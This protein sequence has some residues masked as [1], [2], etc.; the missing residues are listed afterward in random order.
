MKKIKCECCQKNEA[1]HVCEE[2]NTLYC[3]EC[4]SE[5]DYECDCNTPRII[6][7]N[8]ATIK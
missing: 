1:E 3:G 4:A 2:C 5:M 7:L 8:K 6:P